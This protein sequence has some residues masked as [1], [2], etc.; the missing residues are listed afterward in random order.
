MTRLETTLA[1]ELAAL[2]GFLCWR[3]RKVAAVHL[4]DIFIRM[5]V[6]Q[7]R[8]RRFTFLVYFGN[9]LNAVARQVLSPNGEYLLSLKSSSHI[10]LNF[11]MSPTYLSR[12]R[13]FRRVCGAYTAQTC[14]R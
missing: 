5:P 1:Q 11:T 4:D 2:G 12:A 9:L 3:L 7:P 14:S 13:L 10:A 6:D 8:D